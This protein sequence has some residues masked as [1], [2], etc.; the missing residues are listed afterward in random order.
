MKNETTQKSVMEIALSV[1]NDIEKRVKNG[2]SYEDAVAEIEA[3]IV[4]KYES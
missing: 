2:M 1:L 3:E 4:Q